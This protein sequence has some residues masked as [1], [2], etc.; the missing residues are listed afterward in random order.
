MQLIEK[1]IYF[2][3]EKKN[4]SGEK[5]R[6]YRVI[7]YSGPKNLTEKQVAQLTKKIQK[8]QQQIR[9]SMNQFMNSFIQEFVNFSKYL[10]IQ[11][12]EDPVIP[13]VELLSPEN[14]NTSNGEQNEP[15]W[16][17]MLKDALSESK[18]TY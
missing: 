5:S 13:I 4:S 6:L 9:N 3:P 18:E 7:T 17:Q 11:L 1:N 8:R 16:W 14:V 15:P 12:D 2:N 10:P